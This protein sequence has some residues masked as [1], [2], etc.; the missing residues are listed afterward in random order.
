MKTILV[1]G[2]LGFIGSHFIELALA[3]GYRVRNIDKV[4]YASNVDFFEPWPP[5]YFFVKQDIMDLEVLPQC[6]YIVHFAAESHVDRSISNSNVFMNSNI[7]GTHRLL[8]LL[9]LAKLENIET[10]E[11]YQCPSLLYIGTDEVFG[12]IEEGFFKEDERHNPSNP[13]SATKSAAE[14][15]VKAWGRTYNLPYQ[16]T[17]TTNNYGERQHSEKLIPHCIT[18]ILKNGKIKIHGT[19]EYVRNW[20]YVKDNCEAILKVMEEGANQETYHISSN[21]EYSVVDIVEKICEKMGVNS[22]D[23]VQFVSNRSGQD[24]RYALDNTKIVKEL[25][26]NQ[27]HDL[28]SVLDKIIGDYRD[29]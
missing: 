12:D 9:R 14:M 20:I 11:P 1:T 19:G 28:D 5:N 26:W 18:Q 27:H 29:K 10:G 8:E 2:G 24:V 16:I 6:D 21:E 22:K 3:R 25:G 17:R 7:L 15:L 23:F 4:T 13:Y